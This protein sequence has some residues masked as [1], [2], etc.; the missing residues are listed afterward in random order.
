MR[1]K[2]FLNEDPNNVGDVHK[3]AIDTLLTVPEMDGFYEFYRFMNAA[4]AEPDKSIPSTGML[5]DNP[6]AL[7]YT[8]HDYDMIKKAASKMGKTV[9]A[10]TPSGSNEING[11]NSTS[12]VAKLKKNKYGV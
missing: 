1:A 2:E 4:A 8:Q 9:K 10:V 5:R 11:T 6:V 7:P 12:P 3:A